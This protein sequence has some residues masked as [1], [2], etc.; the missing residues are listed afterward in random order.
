MAQEVR[1]CSIEWEGRRTLERTGRSEK[2]KDMTIKIYCPCQWC[3]STTMDPFQSETS[4]STEQWQEEKSC[5]FHDDSMNETRFFNWPKYQNCLSKNNSIPTSHSDWPIVSELLAQAPFSTQFFLFP[6]TNPHPALF[7][8][9]RIVLVFFINVTTPKASDSYQGHLGSAI[10]WCCSYLTGF[11]VKLKANKWTTKHQTLSF[12]QYTSILASIL[13]YSV[14]CNK[15]STGNSWLCNLCYPEGK[16]T[17]RAP[18]YPQ[19]DKFKNVLTDILDTQVFVCPLGECI[20]EQ[21]M[22]CLLFS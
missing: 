16:G 7:S 8:K 12:S 4:V 15:A 1:R 3:A 22:L 14:I 11:Y 20:Y 2:T 10:R 6:W 19:P 13:S 17:K 9:D 18:L 5:N 21:K